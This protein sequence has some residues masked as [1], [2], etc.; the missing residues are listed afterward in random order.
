MNKFKELKKQMGRYDVYIILALLMMPVSF[1]RST[2]GDVGLIAS[3]NVFRIMFAGIAIGLVVL[4]S[5]RDILTII[6]PRGVFKWFFAY[7]LFGIFSFFNSPWVSYSF[8]KYVE[9]TVLLVVILYFYKKSRFYKS[10]FRTAF[11]LSLI[12]IKVMLL[13]AILGLII[14]PSRAILIPDA[15]N[16]TS[17]A[18]LPFQLQG[19]IVPLSNTAVCFYAGYAFYVTFV[20]IIEA[21]SRRTKLLL[22]ALV[23]AVVAVLSMSRMALLGTAIACFVYI[24]F[25]CKKGNVKFFV[26]FAGIILAIIGGNFILTFMLR[27]QNAAEVTSVTGRTRWWS[28]A[29]TVYSN[30]SVWE[31]L[32]G[33]GFAAGERVV[34]RASSDLM[35]TLDSDYFANLISCGAVGL[36]CILGAIITSLSQLMNI[37]RVA[38]SVEEIERLWI[39][40]AA[41]I[42]I[43]TL[44]RLFTVTTFSLL[45]IYL[46]MY[47]FA[48]SYI[49]TVRY[50]KVG[51]EDYE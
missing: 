43:I 1:S 23:Y 9:Y 17:D 29:L 10:I 22:E 40:N 12:Y 38:A 42:M 15:Y 3:G 33:F 44:V 11:E 49:S 45:T 21:K 46:I 47:L 19:W 8:V 37:S 2:Y 41:G 35:S 25:F 5:Y 51:D 18:I 7:W 24:F 26:L 31:K 27:G 34:A 16:P 14:S 48:T 30:G 39:Y 13:I 28:Y 50:L 4:G 36:M 20:S 32:F 6:I